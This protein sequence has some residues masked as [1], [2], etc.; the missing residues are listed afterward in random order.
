MTETRRQLTGTINGS[1]ALGSEAIALLYGVDAEVVRA[2]VNFDGPDHHDV[3][4]IPADWMKAAR[5]RWREA[6]AVTGSDEL[7]SV[8]GYWAQRDL[9]C[10][11]TL[12]S[13]GDAFLTGVTP[14]S[15][16]GCGEC[17]V[18]EWGATALGVPWPAPEPRRRC[19]RLT[20]G[21]NH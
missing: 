11:I 2:S 4:D 5:R 18:E 15:G 14:T 7:L 8:L 16:A 12:D 6:S 1:Q 10:S 9:G 20:D 13:N 19:R 17:S 21:A 3:A